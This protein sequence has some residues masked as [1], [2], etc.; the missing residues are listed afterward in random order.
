MGR[1]L[2]Q[3]QVFKDSIQEADVYLQSIGSGWS[4]MSEFL[5]D[6]AESIINLPKI[7]Q[8]LCTALQVSLVDLLEHWGVKASALAGH[9]SGEIATAYAFGAISKTDAWK[10]A[11][12][13]G[14]LTSEISVLSPRLRGRMMAVALSKEAVEAFLRDITSGTA[15][16]AC[17]NSPENVTI[18]GDDIAI[19]ELE[20]CLQREGIFARKLKVETAYHSAHMRVIE[21]QY[22]QAISGIQ[23]LKASH[24]MSMFSSV[25][26]TLIESEK[27]G[28]AYWAKNLV[29]PVRFSEAVQSLLRSKP[30]KTDILLEL[31]PHGVLQGPL[32]QILDGEGRPKAR[33][34]YVSMLSRGKDARST[35]L[36]MAG[37]LF[38]LGHPIDL[39]KVNMR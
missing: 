7:S 4:L 30:T 5:K 36:E 26:G 34:V 23:T 31:G 32:K 11:Y 39:G 20:E 3:Y 24:G 12:H 27:L 19:S 22:L 18:S 21:N 35:S 16:V 25:T 9:S 28:P 2:L 13:R 10:L 29:S 38:T 15:I 6:E 33:P 8:P 17:I 37:S 14:R 1:Q